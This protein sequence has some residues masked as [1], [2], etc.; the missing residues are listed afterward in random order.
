[1]RCELPR[2]FIRGV[3]KKKNKKKIEKEGNISTWLH[4]DH[5]NA[6]LCGRTGNRR[7]FCVGKAEKGVIFNNFR[8]R[9]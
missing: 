8:P 4:L 2:Y 5:G 6:I 9:H 7:H 3:K 1:V